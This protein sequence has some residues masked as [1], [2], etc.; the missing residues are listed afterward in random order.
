[1]LMSS[2]GV[3]ANTRVII[4]A[5]TKKTTDSWKIPGGHTNLLNN[6]YTLDIAD[7]SAKLTKAT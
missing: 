4:A 2:L 3:N 7:N 1:M 5:I 6:M